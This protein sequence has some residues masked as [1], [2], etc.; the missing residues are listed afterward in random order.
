ML[1]HVFGNKNY[2]WLNFIF[3]LIEKFLMILKRK[4]VLALLK[5]ILSQFHRR[6]LFLTWKLLFSQLLCCTS[7]FN[8]EFCVS[9]EQK[10]P[11]VPRQ[12]KPGR[13][14]GGL[15]SVVALVVCPAG[16]SRGGCIP[17]TSERCVS[18]A[19]VQRQR[20]EQVGVLSS[21]TPPLP[22]PCRRGSARPV[23]VPAF[24]CCSVDSGRNVSPWALLWGRSKPAVGRACL[25]WAGPG[26]QL[27]HGGSHWWDHGS[28]AAH[29]G[30]CCHLLPAPAVTRG[31]SVS[32]HSE[33]CRH[34]APQRL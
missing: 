25:P 20:L 31:G 15:F 34:P 8:F 9:F 26:R 1:Q 4:S 17:C 27:Q 30:S 10:S 19:R 6:D 2:V 3:C 7:L 21:P 18:V 32:G 24:L 16:L 12:H 11:L 29:C 13:Q 33:S 22:G 14:G 5:E 28:L 23:R